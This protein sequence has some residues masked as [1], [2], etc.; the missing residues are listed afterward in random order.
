MSVRKT[1]SMTLAALI[2]APALASAA[3]RDAGPEASADV[4]TRRTAK[5]GPVAADVGDADSFGRN[6]KWLGVADMTVT[7]ADDC[8]GFDPASNCE[9]LAP[10]GGVTSF[11]FEDL[12]HITLPEKA[13]NSLFCHWFSPVLNI[14][15]GN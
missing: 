12:G 2:L 11:V 1:L 14:T 3:P 9:V 13:T 7:L 10:G 6:V 15:Y 5:A 8:T 4:P